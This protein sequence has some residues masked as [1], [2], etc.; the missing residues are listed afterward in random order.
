[1][2]MNTNKMKIRSF[3]LLIVCF[4]ASIAVSAKG[5]EKVY[6]FGVSESFTDSTIY[7]TEIQLIEGAQIQHK[8]K[9]LLERAKYSAQLKNYMSREMGQGDRVNVLFFNKR[10]KRL[11]K[12]FLKVRNRY[13]ARKNM[14][15]EVLPA[16]R[17]RF[18][19]VGEVFDNNSGTLPASQ[20]ET[21]E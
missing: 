4:V 6:M 13:L 7:L 10:K 18:E 19:W 21:L 2:L 9:F 8:T 12:K 1:M 11:E 3:L 17:F 16:S 15:I 14:K 20:Q 5:K